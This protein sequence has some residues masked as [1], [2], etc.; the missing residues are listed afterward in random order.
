MK[1]LLGIVSFLLAAPCLA[2][3]GV[4]AF[5]FVS[6]IYENYPVELS[7]AVLAPE[8]YAFLAATGVSLVLGVG[9]LIA[10]VYAFSSKARS[11]H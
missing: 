7:E 8:F 5:A 1:Y 11:Q 6:S 2:Y 4:A 9:F 10:G 3:F